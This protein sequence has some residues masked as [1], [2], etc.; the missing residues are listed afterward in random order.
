MEKVD[1]LLQ[2]WTK[3]IVLTIVARLA[4]GFSP[5]SES[6]RQRNHEAPN[7]GIQ[8]RKKT[9]TH[10]RLSC[11]IEYWLRSNHR[12]R[13]IASEFFTDDYVSPAVS[14]GGL[15]SK[16]PKRKLESHPERP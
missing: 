12:D 9:E 8:K 16:P 15:P 6:R 7:S 5:N 11:K 13:S 14:R 2:R 4:H 3:Q 10:D 1:D